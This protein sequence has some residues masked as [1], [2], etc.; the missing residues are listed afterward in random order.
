MIHYSF[1][2]RE[3]KSGCR[4]G[5]WYD[6]KTPGGEQRREKAGGLKL[7]VKDR[8]SQLMCS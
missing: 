2:L 6:R 8:V 1:R 7:T 3:N 5:E 4:S